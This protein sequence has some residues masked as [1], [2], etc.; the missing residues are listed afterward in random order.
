MKQIKMIGV[1]GITTALLPF[2]CRFLNFEGDMF[3]I[4]LIDGDEFEKKNAKRQSFQRIG[5]K[6]KVKAEELYQ[7]FKNLSFRA[8]S[9]FLSE[10]NAVD[11]IQ[12]GDIVFLG[13]DNHKTRKT[14]S[15]YCR[16]LSNIVVIS[17]GNELTDGNVQVYVR[18]ED[19]D[20]TTPLTKF[21]PEID[22]PQD[23]I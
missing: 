18:K 16:T 5:N 1:G 8:V 21:H 13:V 17:G 7:E 10:K 3:R 2:L 20:V 22:N 4:T 12:D 11:F 15:D 23:L 14:V 9:E 6:A 19:K